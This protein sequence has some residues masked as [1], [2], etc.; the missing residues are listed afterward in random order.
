[1][2]SQGEREERE[3]EREEEKKRGVQ[4]WASVFIRV[5]GGVS[6]FS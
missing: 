4:T 6:N 3:G 5:E 1:M 2:R